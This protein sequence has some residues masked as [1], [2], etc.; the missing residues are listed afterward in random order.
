MAGLMKQVRAKLLPAAN[1]SSTF[2]AFRGRK[3]ITLSFV[4]ILTERKML[5]V[6]VQV[7]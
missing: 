3:L 1:E 2:A 7:P 4:E 6:H 5:L